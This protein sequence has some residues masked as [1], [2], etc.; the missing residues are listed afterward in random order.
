MDYKLALDY[1]IMLGTDVQNSHHF[2]VPCSLFDIRQLLYDSQ[3]QG[4]LIHT[5]WTSTH[6]NV[7][8]ALEQFL[9]NSS[10][11]IQM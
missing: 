1:L 11:V 2:P 4:G 7:D 10:E 3:T 5:L 8:R 6:I 9:R